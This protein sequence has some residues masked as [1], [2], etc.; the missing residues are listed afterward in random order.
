M[1]VA[2]PVRAE[3]WSLGTC[4]VHPLFQGSGIGKRIVE[5]GKKRAER[6]KVCAVLTSA[7]GK[8]GFY[9]QA[10]G[11]GEQYGDMCVG[12]GNPLAVVRGRGGLM[13]WYWPEGVKRPAA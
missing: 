12:E 6:D 9:Q 3:C 8:D 5:V 11:F 4:A 1:C 13:Y 2:D 7:E 10:C